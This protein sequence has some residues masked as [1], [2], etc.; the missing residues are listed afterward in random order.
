M[1]NAKIFLVDDDGDHLTQ[2]VETSFVTE[3]NLQILLARYPDLLPGDIQML[4][5]AS[6]VIE[7]ILERITGI[8]ENSSEDSGSIDGK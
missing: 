8:A 5:K 4:D 7:L 6:D 3:E 1:S 2:M